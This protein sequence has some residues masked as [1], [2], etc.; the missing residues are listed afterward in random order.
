LKELDHSHSIVPGNVGT[1]FQDLQ[2]TL[3]PTRGKK[4]YVRKKEDATSK[5][6]ETEKAKAV[7]EKEIS[8]SE[9]QLDLV[10]ELKKQNKLQKEYHKA[11]EKEAKQ[12]ILWQPHPGPQTDF[13]ASPEYEVGFFGG[14]GSGKSDC[15]LVDPI[16][17]VQHDEF[18]G[19]IIRK[20]MPALREI[21][22]RAKRLYPKIIPGTRWKEA[23]KLFEF[24][25]GATIEF[26][27]YD[28][29]DDY[30]R[31]HGREF[32]WLGIDE[33]TQFNSQEYYDNIK[34]VVRS[35]NP[36]LSPRIRCTCNPSG[37]G[38]IWVK[39]YF[40]IEPGI[41]TKVT[42]A[43]FDVGNGLTHTISKKYIIATVFDN[44]SAVDNDPQYIAFLQ[45]LPPSQRKQWLDGDFEAVDGLAFEEFNRNLHIIEPFEIPHSWLRIRGID[46]GYRSK[47]V[48]LW[49]AFDKDGN[50][51]VYRE[52]VTT[53]VTSDE[54]AKMVLDLEQNEYVSYGVMD[55][56]AGVQT[57]INGP[58]VEED[59]LNQ[60][61]ANTHADK[62][63]GSRIHSKQLIHKYLKV[64]PETNI[65]NLRIFNTCKQLINE[66]GSLMVDPNNS[67]D[68][69]QKQEDHAFDALKYALSSRPEPEY[70]GGDYWDTYKRYEQSKPIIVNPKFGY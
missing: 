29:I 27:Y 23:E 30:D 8:P 41:K 22:S 10:A 1:E 43:T 37:P 70:G 34:S 55:G 32:A 68:I 4:K 47:A 62:R 18:K 69:N 61:L 66:L 12:K 56:Q 40:G 44:P 35:P 19:L 49:M 20:T 42:D 24:P 13:L 59:F 36:K 39:D 9:K 14:R 54:F 65:P 26:G 46:W 53:R 16:R 31:Y 2:T 60:G 38:R 28:H 48:C 58:T 7:P 51:F 5:T 45:S 52:L 15:L 50:A 57:G 3:I 6:K 63:A 67:E 11:V 21:I 64:D 33:I 25:S 17:F